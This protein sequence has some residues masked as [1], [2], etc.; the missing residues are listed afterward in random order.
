MAWL[1]FLVFGAVYIAYLL[2]LAPRTAT[3]K[4]CVQARMDR[5]GITDVQSQ[6]AF[7]AIMW[8][9]KNGDPP[10]GR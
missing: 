9:Q 6:E 3:W 4:G 5:L 1:A 2:F 10:S 8:C 7:D